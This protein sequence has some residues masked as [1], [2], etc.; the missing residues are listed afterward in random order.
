[1]DA[2]KCRLSTQ[3]TRWAECAA[4]DGTLCY[5][6]GPRTI[7]EFIQPTI[8]KAA[9]DAGRPSPRIIAAVPVLVT[10]D[11]DAGRSLAA[12]VLSFYETIPSYRRVI[13]REGVASVAATL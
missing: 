11:A 3:H 2:C 13:A 6:A 9:A 8:A 5:L 10:D 4:A 1:M 12:D 7:A